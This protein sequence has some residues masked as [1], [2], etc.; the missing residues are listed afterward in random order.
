MTAETVPVQPWQRRRPG[1]MTIARKELTDHLLSVRFIALL[2]LLA[3]VAAG[4]VYGASRAL[5]EV[6]QQASESGVSTFLRLFTLNAAPVPFSFVTFLGFLA[7][8]LGIA[9]G[10]DAISGEMSQGTMPRLVSQPIYRDDVINGK[11]VAGIAAIGVIMVTVTLVVAGFGILMLG[12]VPTPS[13]VVRLGMWLLATI[14][15][16]CVWLA[17]ATLMSVLF[18]S[19]ATP[20]VVSIG[21]WLVLTLFGG[22]L[23]SLAAG[24]ISPV[25]PAD[26]ASTL[27]NAQTELTLSRLSPVVLYDDA[28]TALLV[29]EVRTLDVI[30]YQQVDRAIPSSL[31]AGQS[32]LLVWPQLVALAAITVVLFALAYV[33]FMR[34]EVRA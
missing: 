6:A 30:T 16:V 10:F 34:R 1:W 31:T 33:S 9:Y 4:T 28:A 5:T 24:I 20:A 22:L 21:I 29:P 18:R 7:P 19:S 14:V 3:L 25:N 27:S 17:L 13:D 8:I 32:V 15:Y 12:V 2:A 26:P 11:F 23:A